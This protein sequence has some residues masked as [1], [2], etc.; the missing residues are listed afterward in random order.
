MSKRAASLAD[1][2]DSLPH[3][4]P[5]RIGL[6]RELELRAVF[7]EAGEAAAI[8]F[9]GE[10]WLRLVHGRRRRRAVRDLRAEASCLILTNRRCHRGRLGVSPE[11]RRAP[12]GRHEEGHRVGEGQLPHEGRTPLATKHDIALIDRAKHRAD[13]ECDEGRPAECWAVLQRARQAPEVLARAGVKPKGRA[14]SQCPGT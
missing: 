10:V 1:A 14:P 11:R 9:R 4:R 2:D 7:N 8:R 3:W 13:E 5:S 6:P 12:P